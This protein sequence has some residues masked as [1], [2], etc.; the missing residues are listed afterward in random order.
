MIYLVG[1]DKARTR[2]GTMIAVSRRAHREKH[3]C[4]QGLE[5]RDRGRLYCPEGRVDKK[6]Q[7]H[8]RY[9]GISS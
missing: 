9:Y 8:V 6:D 7:V 3:A 5:D 4:E 2:K 1:R